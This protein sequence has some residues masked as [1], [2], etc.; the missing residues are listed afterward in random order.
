MCKGKIIL[1][2]IQGLSSTCNIQF[3][4]Y[5]KRNFSLGLKIQYQCLNKILEMPT[6]QEVFFSL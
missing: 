6:W 2:I 5:I 3:K 4:I 1:I